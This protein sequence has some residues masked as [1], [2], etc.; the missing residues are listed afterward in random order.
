MVVS[1]Y[2]RKQSDAE[3]DQPDF[4]MPDDK[5]GQS[6]RILDQR[7]MFCLFDQ[8][9]K[10][11]DDRRKQGYTADNTDDNTFCH[12]D[13]KVF[14]KCECHQTQGCETG[15]RCDGT[16]YDG[17][18]GIGYCMTH[19][20][21]LVARESFF[22]LLETIQ[23]EDRVVHRNTKLKDRYQCLCQIRNLT[24][25]NIRSH[26]IQD[27]DSDTEQE[28]DRHHKGCS[29]NLQHDERKQCCDRHV[30]RQFLQ[31]QILDI[32]YDTGHTADKALLICN[33]THV[34]DSFHRLV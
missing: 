3:N 6:V 7:F 5:T 14:T 21:V 24:Q 25:E 10:D 16:G 12:Y 15:Y 31:T 9:I 8:R 18:E 33:G 34:C 26:V 29:G 27:R 32:G 17:F 2:C 28:Q 19:R 30:D 11:Q 13:T 4:I 20:S 23:Q 22:I 1:V